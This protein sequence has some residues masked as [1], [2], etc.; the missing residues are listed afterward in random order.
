MYDDVRQ[1]ASPGTTLLEFMQSA[2]EAGARS[3]GWDVEDLRY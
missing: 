3:A 1:V 2:Y